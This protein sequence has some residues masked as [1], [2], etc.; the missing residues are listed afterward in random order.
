MAPLSLTDDASEPSPYADDLT[1][2]ILTDGGP[3]LTQ[4]LSKLWSASGQLEEPEDPNASQDASSIPFSDVQNTLLNAV[5]EIHSSNTVSQLQRSSPPPTLANTSLHYSA[6][7]YTAP[8]Q[9]RFLISNKTR[10][11]L[12]IEAPDLRRLIISYSNQSFIL[13]ACRFPKTRNE[14]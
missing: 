2:C 9:V 7:F 11:S 8:R 10:S 1:V 13:K 12:V 4:Q 5:N 3:I 14:P 6:P